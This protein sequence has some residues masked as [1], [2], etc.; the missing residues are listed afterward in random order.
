VTLEK[1]IADLLA[2][3]PSSWAWIF[4]LHFG[5]VLIVGFAFAD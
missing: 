2:E 1:S 3:V 4:I 5:I